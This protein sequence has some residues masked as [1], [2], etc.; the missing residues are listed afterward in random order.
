MLKIK[1]ISSLEKAFPDQKI[2]DFKALD[3]I[4]AL[5][6]ERLSLQ[7]LFCDEEEPRTPVRAHGHLKLEGELATFVSI[8]EVRHVPV[9]MPIGPRYDDNYLRTTPGV[10]PDL[11][12]ELHYRGL[13]TIT[14][15]L[16]ALWLEISIPE[17]FSGDTSLSVSLSYANVNNV[18]FHSFDGSEE[19]ITETASIDIKV[20]DALMPKDELIFTQWFY[21]DCL[22][23]YYGVDV[24]SEEHWRTIENFAS[25]A[26]KYGRNMLLMPLFTPALNTFP[27]YERTCTQLVDVAV[28]G[29]EY[30][31]DFSRVRRWVEM[32][33]RIG[34]KY[35]EI[36]HF[37]EQD[38]AKHSA[39]I[40]GTV[41]GE[42]RRIFGWETEALDPE[43]QRFLAALIPQ[44]L[45]VMKE[46]GEDGKCY[47]HVSDEPN[48]ENLE[49][50]M[51]VKNAIA[52][53]LEGY[54]I[55]DAL[56]D[57]DFYKSGAVKNP[58]P[59]TEH[60]MPFVEEG[61]KDLWV[62]YACNQIIGYSNCYLAMPSWRTRSLGMQLYKYNITGF[63]HWGY[64][65]YNNR[66]SAN[67][68]N[69]YCELSGEGWVP[70]G[71]TFMVYPGFGGE[72][73]YSLRLIVL[74][75]AISDVNAMRLCEKYYSHEFIVSAMESALG[76][77]ITFKRCATSADE[78]LA[79]RECINGLIDEAI[80]NSM[81]E[82]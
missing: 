63:L 61:V 41:D 64:N 35:H 45:T 40:Y 77:E 82:K 14:P 37:Y 30:S 25:A 38:Q 11:L 53:M 59:T 68:I 73:E 26:V 71:D 36:S 10:Y 9:T 23:N 75:D 32:C 51:A 50:Y 12:T 43:Y 80:K 5:R 72:P 13:V 55:M 70:A 74:A 8:K 49:H 27:G 21:C 4:S 20:I 60:A 65:Y 33:R 22:A 47:F 46:L 6:G 15:T 34:V 58:V 16:T 3:K 52:P 42:Y 56:S 31:F 24:W 17:D 39:K 78:M 67:A 29:G 19:W 57:V 2:C 18:A 66:G 54:K 28:T 48:K 62:Y 1:I 76:A 69:P 79:V 44:F 81:E 7:L